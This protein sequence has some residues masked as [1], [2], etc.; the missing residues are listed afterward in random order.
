MSNDAEASSSVFTISTYFKQG[1]GSR[2]PG[3]QWGQLAPQLESFG[4]VDP[5]LWTVEV[6]HFYFCLFLDLNLGPSQK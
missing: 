3:G 6:V 5:Q 1:R 2:G 4:S